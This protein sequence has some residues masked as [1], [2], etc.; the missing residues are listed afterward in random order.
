MYQQCDKRNSFHEQTAE[1]CRPLHC[2]VSDEQSSIHVQHSF[3]TTTMTTARNECSMFLSLSLFLSST[4]TLS[5]TPQTLKTPQLI[6]KSRRDVA[7][8]SHYTCNRHPT[9]RNYL[10]SFTPKKRILTFRDSYGKVSLIPPLDLRHLCM[11][12]REIGYRGL[13]FLG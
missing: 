3:S 11:R 12:C 7:R 13:C 5:F 1:A 10:L 9:R 6:C 2:P 8:Q 4:L